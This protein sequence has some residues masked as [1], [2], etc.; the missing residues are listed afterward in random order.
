MGTHTIW[1][2]G[3][4]LWGQPLTRDSSSM[5]GQ[6]FEVSISGIYSVLLAEFGGKGDR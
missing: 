6:V 1:G 2:E 4:K 5:Q 3:K